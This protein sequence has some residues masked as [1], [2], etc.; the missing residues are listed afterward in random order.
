MLSILRHTTYRHLFAAQ[1]LSLIGTGLTTVALGLLAYDLAGADAGRVLGT[2]LALKMVA[3][4]GIAPVAGALVGLLPRRRFLVLLDLMRAG[5]VLLLPF[6]TEVWQIYALVF[7][8]Q[9]FSAAFTPTFQATIP[10]ILPDEEEYTEA[11]SLSRLAYDLESLVSPMLAGALLTVMSF[12]WLFTLNAAGFLAS[13]ALVGTVVLPAVA[14]KTERPFVK[15]VTRGSWIYLA[16]PRLRGLLALSFAV[17]SAGSMVIVNTVVIVKGTFGGTDGNVALAFAAYGLGSMAVALSLPRLLAAR[18]GGAARI[19]P[20]QAMLAGGA[21]LPL[22]LVLTA[23]SSSYVA[24]VAIW[25]LIG[26]GSSLVQTPGGLLLRRSSHP[27]DRPA[28]FAAQFALS[29]ACW[30][31]AYP[32]A[33]WLGATVGITTTALVLAVAATCGVGAAAILWPRRDPMTIEHE[34]IPVAH[35]HGDGDPVH[36]STAGADP[37][38]DCWHRH[39]PIRHAHAFVIDDHH[40]IWP[41]H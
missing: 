16:T 11:L 18:T 32:A 26:V 19:E 34:H 14:A 4:V 2:A 21:L 5:M 39:R 33:G 24:L 6:V 12:H 27:E 41:R 28:L 20:R 36:H 3:Y 13:A 15:R 30:L 31:L 1:V 35:R 10:D 25:A 22:G 8:F 23:A 17:S 38:G 40:P 37:N 29:H 7:A 9:S